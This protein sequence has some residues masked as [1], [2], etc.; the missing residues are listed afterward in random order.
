[1]WPRSLNRR[2]FP[3]TNLNGGPVSNFQEQ[4]ASSGFVLVRKSKGG[5]F[6]IDLHAGR[7]PD[8]IHQQPGGALGPADHGELDAVGL[9]GEVANFPVRVEEPSLTLDSL[10]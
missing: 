8:A 7:L 4:A 1:M 9:L 2:T 3:K 10:A 6:P 5:I